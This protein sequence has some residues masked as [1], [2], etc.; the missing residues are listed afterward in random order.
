[1]VLMVSFGFLPFWLVMPLWLLGISLVATWMEPSLHGPEALIGW[2]RIGLRRFLTAAWA[3]PKVR[4]ALIAGGICMLGL[5]YIGGFTWP[6]QRADWRPSTVLATILLAGTIAAST[7]PCA[8]F[9]VQTVDERRRRH[10]EWAS[11]P[12][13]A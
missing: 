6:L 5:A 10:E 9:L 11:L 2:P 7:L 4:V 13:E 3:V 1:M 12:I 8:W